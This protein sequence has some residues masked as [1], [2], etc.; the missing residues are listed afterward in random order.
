MPCCCLCTYRQSQQVEKYVFELIEELKR[1]MNPAETINL[2]V[3]HTDPTLC[4]QREEPWSINMLFSPLSLA[5]VLF[6]FPSSPPQ[7]SF[8]CLHPDSKQKTR[9]QSCLPCRFYN[10][11]GQLCHR[12]TEALV[13]GQTSVLQWLLRYYWT[14][15]LSIFLFFPPLCLYFQ[16]K[17]KNYCKWSMNCTSPCFCLSLYFRFLFTEAIVAA[18][19]NQ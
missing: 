11:I 7:G 19:L 2:E 12:N 13:K 4:T 15:F 18:E 8:Q 17:S 5:H 16:S 14:F 10:L 3:T 1:K 9:C 6:M